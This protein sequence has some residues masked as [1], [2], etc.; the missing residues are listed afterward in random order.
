LSENDRQQLA[1]VI[2]KQPKSVKVEEWKTLPL[3]TDEDRHEWWSQRCQLMSPPAQSEAT[4]VFEDTTTPQETWADTSPSS[5]HY[6]DI[7]SPAMPQTAHAM[8]SMAQQTI[9]T[10]PWQSALN[11]T[12][13]DDLG[14]YN[15]NNNNNN[16]THAAFATT[17]SVTGRSDGRSGTIMAPTEAFAVVN[18]PNL[19]AERLRKYF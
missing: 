9:L 4:R 15:N 8:P 11:V 12:M 16:N 19:S 14:S 1:N 3:V 10:A 17:S 18:P 13:S 5:A 7:H 6:E 2:Q